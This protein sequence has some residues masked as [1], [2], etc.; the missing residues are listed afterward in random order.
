MTDALLAELTIHHARDCML[1]PDINMWSN[2][3]NCL[4][5]KMALHLFLIIMVRW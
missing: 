4:M 1:Q 2:C 5:T 3:V